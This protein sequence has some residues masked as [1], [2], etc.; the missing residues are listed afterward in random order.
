MRASTRRGA[1][2]TR[3]SRPAGSVHES[4][5]PAPGESPSGDGDVS[6]L[7]SFPVIGIGA[8]AGG[9]EA[10]SQVFAELPADLNAA[11]I[12]VMHLDPHHA[13]VLPDLLGANS[14]LSVVHVTDG[15]PIEPNRAFVIP[16]NSRLGIVEGKL[17]LMPRPA[18]RSQFKP[19]DFFFRTLA[20]YAQ[21]RAIGIVLSGTDADGA[22]GLRDIKGIGGITIAQDPNTAKY[23]GMPRAAIQTG[24]VDLV[25]QPHEVARELVHIARH[26]Y[27]APVQ[28]AKTGKNPGEADEQL[29][30]IFLMLREAT[31]V[32]FSHYK[33]A[34]IRRRLER[35]MVLHKTDS[36]DHYIKFLHRDPSEVRALYQDLLIHV[37]RFF[38]DPESFELLAGKV[39]PQLVSK[40]GGSQA[41]RIWVP[42]CSTGEEA[43]SVAIAI[44]EFLGEQSAVV[45]IQIFATD[46]SETAVEQARSGTYPES[47]AADVSPERLTRF[48]TKSG[49]T[50]RI[51]KTV[52]DMC[53]F[54]RQDLTR[55]PPFS[56][57]DLILCRNVLIYLSPALQRRLMN[58]FHYALRHNGFLMLGSAETIGPSIDLFAVSDRRHRLYTKRGS[59]GRADLHFP[60]VDYRHD[61]ADAGRKLT[62]DLRTAGNVQNEANRLVIARYA[63]AG[64][65][66]NSDL[67]I[68]QFRGQTG[69]YLEP[70]PGEASLNLLKMAREGLLHAVRTAV[71]EARHRNQS[72]RKERV[73]VTYNGSVSDVN[74][75][76]IPLAAAR[77]GRHFLVLFE[78][79]SPAPI[80]GAGRRP[81]KNKQ[82]APTEAEHVR[83]LR[84]ELAASREYLQSIIQDLEAA[85]EELQS[86][87]EEIL[88]ADEELQSTNEELDTAKE[89]LQSTN[90]E[91]NTVNEELQARNED[92]SQ[93]N[94]DLVNLLGSVQ[95]AIVMVA[96]DLRIRRFTPMAEKIL[97]LIPTDVGRPIG[98]LKPNIDCPDLEKLIVE[99]IESV[100]TKERQVR[101]HNGKPYWLRIRPYK[102]VDNRIDGA[103]L[104]LVEADAEKSGD[105][106]DQ[107]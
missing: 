87:N 12:V 59:A 45:P 92:L 75:E 3:S 43:Y 48:F 103:V 27:V 63:P 6:T 77:E 31:G 62:V 94:N 15:M 32:D 84:E 16:P 19:V 1:A 104:A 101:E 76:V 44:L 28:F 64:V 18:D 21:D 10:C 42:G 93:A 105:S 46:V 95:I 61:R 91:L 35:R 74:L 37:T 11:L 69:S 60:P 39:F 68:I 78:P 9:L 72:V 8:S 29:Q 24:M 79:A 88:S 106:A 90:E 40:R 97:N 85:N 81:L 99:A 22:V 2:R 57:L 51:S 80:R 38:R 100:S 7:P 26:P 30:K 107:P 20:A 98:A 73:R 33:L 49:A 55:D 66:I 4:R 89:E 13:S 102:S 82:A 65:I 71:H 83:R 17:R 54:A 5:R 86:A 23:D 96:R 53:V 67:Q 36:V 70:A 56:K 25:L 14:K 58:V 34:T 52:R 47:I 50:Y 41:I